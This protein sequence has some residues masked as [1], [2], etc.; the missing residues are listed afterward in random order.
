MEI[1]INAEKIEGLNKDSRI[2]INGFEIGNVKNLKI[3]KDGSIN[4]QCNVNS[5][6]EI[7]IDSKFKI[8]GVNFLGSKEIA[9]ELGKSSKKIKNGEKI[10]LTKAE[11]N[12]L[13]ESLNSKIADLFENLIGTKKQDS[14]LIELRRLNENLEKGK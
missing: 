3:A 5:E 14:I 8:E 1:T 7:P 12:N 13:N 11:L 6:M 9:V 10:K 4:I 2:T